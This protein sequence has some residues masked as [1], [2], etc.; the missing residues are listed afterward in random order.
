MTET[1]S[2]KRSGTSLL[3]DT[4]VIWIGFALQWSVPQLNEA[5][6][7]ILNNALL[8]ALRRAS[9]CVLQQIGNLKPVFSVHTF[10]VNPTDKK[11]ALAAIRQALD[12]LG[13]RNISVLAIVTPE[14]V[15]DTNEGRII[16]GTSFGET[17]LKQEDMEA[18]AQN[19][20]AKIA[21][22]EKVLDHIK[23]LSGFSKPPEQPENPT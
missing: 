23:N 4:S 21:F 22:N 8:A 16:G 18:F 20:A 2:P 15:W 10:V 17:F 14:G 12:E 19:V 13:L 6:F 5:S 11:S 7:F 3:M 1:N 9:V